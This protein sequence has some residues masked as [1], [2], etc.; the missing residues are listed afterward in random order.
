M[1]KSA[2]VEMRRGGELRKLKSM[3]AQSGFSVI[4]MRRRQSPR[5]MPFLRQAPAQIARQLHLDLPPL[6]LNSGTG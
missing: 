5:G 2:A 1:A 6:Y 3:T 4:T